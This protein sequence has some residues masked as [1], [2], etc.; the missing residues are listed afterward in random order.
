MGPIPVPG[1]QVRVAQDRRLECS[2]EF[3]GDGPPIGFG[4]MNDASSVESDS[5]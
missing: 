2:G 5:T 4:G 3:V 1:G